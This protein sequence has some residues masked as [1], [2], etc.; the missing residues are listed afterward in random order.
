MRVG[1][2]KIL[3]IDEEKDLTEPLV[4]GLEQ[5]GFQVNA[6]NDPEV[7]VSKFRAG[8]YRLVICD[9]SMRRMNGFEVNREL[10]KIDRVTKVCF[11]TAF[12]IHETEFRKLFPESEVNCFLDKTK[13]TTVLVQSIIQLLSGDAGK[14]DQECTQR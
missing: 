5:N 13:P 14:L 1:L 4:I 6:F 8:V 11:L 7:A 3:I 10:K 9:I 12:E 2:R